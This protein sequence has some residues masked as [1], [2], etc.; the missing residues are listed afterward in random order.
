MLMKLTQ[1]TD[2]T[3]ATGMK[4]TPVKQT[5]Q[6]LDPQNTVFVGAL[7]GMHADCRGSRSHRPGTSEVSSVLLLLLLNLLPAVG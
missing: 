4:S 2:D 6:R 7:L 3:M 5:S 1:T